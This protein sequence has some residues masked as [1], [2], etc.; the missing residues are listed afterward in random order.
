MRIFALNWGKKSLAGGVIAEKRHGGHGQYFGR[1]IGGI[2]QAMQLAGIEMHRVAGAEGVV[3]TL[4]GVDD[5]PA[6]HVGE[7][8]ALMRDQFRLIAH[9][10]VHLHRVDRIT[11]K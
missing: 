9:R 5:L 4:D 11:G 10:N 6:E 7:L 8:H 3:A 2:G 1:G